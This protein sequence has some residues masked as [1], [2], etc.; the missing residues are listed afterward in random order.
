MVV[1]TKCIICL[2]M[3]ETP[4]AV[5]A[6]LAPKDDMVF[7]VKRERKHGHES[8]SKSYTVLIRRKT[9]TKFPADLLWGSEIGQMIEWKE[10]L[11]L[12]LLMHTEYTCVLMRSDIGS[13]EPILSKMIDANMKNAAQQCQ[14]GCLITC[15]RV[16]PIL[17]PEGEASRSTYPQI[18]FDVHEMMDTIILSRES[19]CFSIALLAHVYESWGEPTGIFKD[20]SINDGQAERSSSNKPLVAFSGF[21]RYENI[22]DS[23]VNNPSPVQ[24]LLRQ[25]TSPALLV[26]KLVGK[27]DGLEDEPPLLQ[28]AILTMR[29]QDNSGLCQVHVKSSALP[30]GALALSCDVSSLNIDAHSLATTLTAWH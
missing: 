3:F 10:S 5:Q 1:L 30:D 4:E 11:K 8:P 17:S 28:E 2:Q 16:H 27:S 24:A 20:G 13:I 15:R 29:G 19:D 14:P 23:I 18:H 21:V 26:Q 22:K 6:T 12:C 9:K 25:V 7:F